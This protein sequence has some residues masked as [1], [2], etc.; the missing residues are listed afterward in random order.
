MLT[1]EQPI[2]AKV[3]KNFV[4][5]LGNDAVFFVYVYGQNGF[6]LYGEPIEA[7]ETY[8]AH[9]V[10]CR[11]AGA[12]M[13]YGDVFLL[14]KK[15]SRIAFPL[16]TI[17]K[18]LPKGHYSLFVHFPKSNLL[19]PVEGC[20]NFEKIIEKKLLAVKYVHICKIYSC[21]TTVVASRF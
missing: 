13:L 10:S 18:Y 20:S 21:K 4:S 6:K 11:I 16:N 5:F 9:N 12:I 15:G 17:K 7:S 14:A 2:F 1:R 19:V 8:V 3:A